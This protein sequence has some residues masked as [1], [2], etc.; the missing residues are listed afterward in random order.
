M[1][2]YRWKEPFDVL[3]LT[4]HVD[5]RGFLIELLRFQ[6]LSIPPGGQLYTFSINPGK[7]RGDHFHEHKREWFTCVQGEALVLLSSKDGVGHT[8]VLSPRSPK[9][10]Y[11][12]PGT[13]HALMNQGEETAVIVSYGS[14]QHDPAD[15][16]TY[17][18][19]V[20][21]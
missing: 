10:V 7:R 16:D 8:V 4:P 12:S 2:A 9:M 6:D 18:R 3:D 1:D 5:V 19:V 13:A 11:A 14:E 20:E 17:K 21:L 15:P